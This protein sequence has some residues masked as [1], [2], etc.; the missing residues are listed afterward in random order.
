MRGGGGHVCRD[1]SMNPANLSAL[2]RRFDGP[3][4]RALWLKG[5]FARGDAGPFSDVDID[6]LL[7][8][9]ADVE[10]ASGS[11]LIDE[12][13]VV[14]SDVRAADLARCFVEPRVA[15]NAVLGLRSAQSLI[16]RDGSFVEMQTQANH[17]VWDEAMQ[18]RADAWA[19]AELVG[20]SEEVGKG[21]AGLQRGS[22]GHLLQARF[23]LSWGLLRVVQVQRGVLVET[24]NELPG[25]VMN[26]VGMGSEWARLCRAAFGLE[27]TASSLPEA[28]RAGLRLYVETARLLGSAVRDEDVPIVAWAASRISI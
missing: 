20:W 14:V 9:D 28:V 17:F 5:S 1:P 8:D 2:A 7:A 24:E 18:Q 3:G 13:L 23:G 4:V 6:R 12:W 21:L 11:Y 27:P 25:A 26:A 22:V 10:P 19:S 16:D 15:V